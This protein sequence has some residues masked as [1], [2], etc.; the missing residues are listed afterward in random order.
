VNKNTSEL[1]DMLDQTDLTDIYR[2]F[3]PATAQNAL[4]L[5]AHRTFSKRDHILGH[6]IKLCKCKKVKKTPHI[7]SDRNGIK[8]KFN[9]IRSY[10]KY[11]LLKKS[12]CGMTNGSLKT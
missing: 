3:H 1:I 4:Y 6:K 5:V 9:S 2:L 7:L 12:H 11:S 10:R 8:L